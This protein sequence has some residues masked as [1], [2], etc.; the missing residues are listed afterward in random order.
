MI[1]TSAS[2]TVPPLANWVLPESIVIPHTTHGDFVHC[3]LRHT[4]DGLQLAFTLSLSPPDLPRTIIQE[5]IVQAAVWA[6]V[7][8][9]QLRGVLA[10]KRP[11]TVAIPGNH[12][13]WQRVRGPETVPAI[14]WLIRPLFCD[15]QEN[16]AMR[17]FQRTGVA[18][19]L[20]HQT[21]ILADDMGLGKTLQVLE[22]V[23]TMVYRDQVRTVLVLCPR[24][25]VSTWEFEAQKWAPE[26][27]MACSTSWQDDPSSLWAM[28]AG[29][30]HL[31][32]MH[33][34][35]FKNLAPDKIEQA[36]VQKLVLDEAHRVRRSEAAVT[37]AVRSI[38]S[39]ST[40]ALTG[41]PIERDVEDLSTLLSIL[42][43]SRYSAQLHVLG[44]DTIRSMAKPL[45]L[46][47]RKADVL[48]DLP[49]VSEL[50]HY[51]DLTPEQRKVYDE[52]V[53]SRSTQTSGELL[54]LIGKLLTICDA[55]PATG[56]SSK[57]EHMVDQIECVAEQCEKAVVF[58]Y[59]LSPL[60]AIGGL[61]ELRGIKY[62][63]LDGAMQI[64]ERD[65]VVSA[66]RSGRGIA[67]LLASSRVAAEGL[68]LTEANHAFFINRWWNPSSNDQA[69][70][71]IVRIGQD[72][73]VS[74]HSYVCTN[75]IEERLED[76]LGAKRELVDHVVNA[77]AIEDIQ[78][79][80]ELADSEV[81]E[82][83]RLVSQGTSGLRGD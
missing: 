23:R 14:G 59:R 58:S 56:E 15:F 16:D 25:L 38:H 60:D 40:W 71:R 51:V 33:Y 2:A 10:R 81:F 12:Q 18:W 42:E 76:I 53:R 47:R 26:L 52:A 82:L 17:A 32:V 80:Q 64:T 6:Q 37:T 83:E 27:T 79:L 9:R 3:E 20:D 77:L 39:G 24:T 63:R 69:R 65:A 49:T 74:I 13:L 19:L 35:Q 70:D 43:P 61:L 45:I 7:A 50:T 78:E 62:V 72:R 5:R 11:A 41:T 67:A 30:V 54:A 48:A 28:A 57:L 68:T 44:P 31:L 29:R 73:P 34:D 21:G 8:S 46:R 36:N 66:F 1:Q 75:T 55:D 4:Q 22:A